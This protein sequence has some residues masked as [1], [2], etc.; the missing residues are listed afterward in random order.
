MRVAVLCVLSAALAAPA[1]GQ[2]AAPSPF[3]YHLGLKAPEDGPRMPNLRLEYERASSGTSESFTSHWSARARA[4]AD[5][6]SR[7]DRNP[8]DS[9]AEGAFGYLWTLSGRSPSPE[10]FDTSSSAGTDYGAIGIY[11]DARYETNQSFSEQL[12]SAQLR[13]IYTHG[14]HTGA[15]LLLPQTQL[16]V[17]V[18]RAV[19]SEVRD[20]LGVDSESNLRV[21]GEAYW[22]VDFAAF[23]TGAASRISLLGTWRAFRTNGLDD[24][25]GALGF[26]SGN[27]FAAEAGYAVRFWS[28]TGLFV[29]WSHGR[30]PSQPVNIGAWQVGVRRM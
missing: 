2:A 28:V 23:T 17:G 18:T 1:Y 11:G 21:E 14:H 12:G 8:D 16:A 3:S 9:F 27:Y 5:L 7:A 10:V 6:V 25:L 19:D 22:I 15:W 29:R 30:L 24:R 4:K 20:A 13:V 26:E